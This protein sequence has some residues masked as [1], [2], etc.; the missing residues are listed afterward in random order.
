VKASQAGNTDYNPAPDV[1]RS[2]SIAKADQTIS[3]AAL[4]NKG[5]GDPD[6][7]VSATA[8]SGL[9]VS[10]NATGACTVSGSTVH[11]TGAGACT[12]TASQAGTGNYNPAPDVGRTFYVLWGFT[13]FY[14]PVDNPPTVNTVQAGSAIPVKFGLGGDRGLSIM[15]AGSP[16]SVGISC[17]T[18]AAQDAIEE[19]VTAGQ[20]SLNYGS[21]QYVYVWKTDKA[22]AGTCRQLLVKLVDGSTHTAYFKF[23]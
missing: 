14:S 19:T 3:F 17:S 15:A 16:A 20:S 1:S 6:F 11:L 13:G 18:S 21:G 10:F 12:I 22:W 23:K 2:F 7:S 4:P 8:S 5:Y 9:A